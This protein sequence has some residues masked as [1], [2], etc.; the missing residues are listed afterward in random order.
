MDIEASPYHLLTAEQADFFTSRI[1]K[2]IAALFHKDHHNNSSDY[3]KTYLTVEEFSFYASRL[4]RPAKNQDIIQLLKLSLSAIANLPAID[5][6][7]AFSP[8][9]A[10]TETLL[11][12]LETHGPGPGIVRLKVKP[13]IVAGIVFGYKGKFFDFSLASKLREK[14]AQL[15]GIPQKK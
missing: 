2:L 9:L 1:N 14:Y 15:S 3:L 11:A 4:P 8:T 10:F 6:H 5:V 12:W 13:D 7:L